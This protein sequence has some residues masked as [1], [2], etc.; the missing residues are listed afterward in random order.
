[1]TCL[2]VLS[3]SCDISDT[4]KEKCGLPGREDGAIGVCPNVLGILSDLKKE[5]KK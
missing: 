1:M 2:C 5:I 4:L 3:T